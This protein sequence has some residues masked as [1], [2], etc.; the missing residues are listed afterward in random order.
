MS[1]LQRLFDLTAVDVNSWINNYT[2]IKKLQSLN[3]ALIS[4]KSYQ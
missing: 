1:Q 4:D 3:P 2:H